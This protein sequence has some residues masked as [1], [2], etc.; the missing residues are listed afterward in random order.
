LFAESSEQ[1]KRETSLLSI[2]DSLEL[3]PLFV[4]VPTIGQSSR[5]LPVFFSDTAE[6]LIHGYQQGLMIPCVHRWE[7]AIS[8]NLTGIS[9]TI[10]FFAGRPKIGNDK[11]HLQQRLSLASSTR[12]VIQSKQ[13]DDDSL[14]DQ[15]AL[16]A[17]P[18]LKNEVGYLFEEDEDSVLIQDAGADEGNAVADDTLSVDQAIEITFSGGWRALFAREQA[19]NFVAPDTRRVEERFVR[20]LRVGDTALIIPSQPRQSL[21][22]LII[23]RVHQHPS[24]ELHLALLRRWREDLQAGYQRWAQLHRDPLARLLQEIQDAGSSVTSMLAVRFWL[25]GTTLCPADSDDLLR[26]A[27]LLNLAFV[28]ARYRQIANAASRIRGLH[29]GLSNRLNRWLNDQARGM[30][31]SHDAEV[32]DPALGLTFGDLRS[33]LIVAEVVSIREV[34]GPFLRDTLGLIERVTTDD[35]RRAIA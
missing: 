35:T 14:D 25:N 3:V 22:A 27:E 34:P 26:V 33:S 31:D 8:P 16:W 1:F 4:G 6:V 15:E 24:I 19:I 23:S 21:Y 20:A 17:S 5:L 28:R 11:I 32:I 30:G 13:E 10:D 12:L 2:P 9:E 7:E 29:R 18:D